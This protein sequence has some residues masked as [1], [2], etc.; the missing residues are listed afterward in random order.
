M[1]FLLISFTLQAVYIVGQIRRELRAIQGE[2]F[3]II[4]KSFADMLELEVE[5]NE[6]QLQGFATAL[7]SNG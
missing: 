1:T 3:S 4:A 5:G 7:S 2:N 6:N